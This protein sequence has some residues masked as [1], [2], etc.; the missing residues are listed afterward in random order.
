MNRYSS[1]FSIS[2][3]SGSSTNIC[4]YILTAAKNGRKIVSNNNIF[5]CLFMED[6]F[7][8]LY[9]QPDL[10][11]K[12]DTKRKKEAAEN[13][14]RKA[15]QWENA[16]RPKTIMEIHA[17]L[18]TIEE[19]TGNGEKNSIDFFYQLQKCFITRLK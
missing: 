15:L 4:G 7:S 1:S 11:I 19:S 13:L 10:R 12:L 17:L 8:P 2:N 18:A 9:F 5:K 16:E 14:A 3:P 6:I